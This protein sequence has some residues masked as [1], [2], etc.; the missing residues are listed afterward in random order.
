MLSVL[1][2]MKWL[3]CLSIVMLMTGCIPADKLKSVSVA[4]GYCP[5]GCGLTAVEIRRALDYHYFG[6]KNATLKGNYEG[7]YSKEQWADLETAIQHID[8]TKLKATRGRSGEELMVEVIITEQGQS[9]HIKSD[10][11]NLPNILKPVVNSLLDSYKTVKLTKTDEPYP[12]KTTFQEGG[13]LT[14]GPMPNAGGN[15]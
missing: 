14:Q 11:P 2:I 10:Y 9:T 3:G 5:G 8:L 4:V 1:I 6:D 15:N 13:K 12:F 7:Q